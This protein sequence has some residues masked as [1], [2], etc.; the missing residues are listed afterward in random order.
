MKIELQEIVKTYGTVRANDRVDLTVESGS[1][2]GL[3]GENGAGKSTLMKILSGYVA[4][5][6]GRVLC[7]GREVKLGSPAAA[8]RLGIGML[9]QDPLDFPAL[10][11]LDNFLLGRRTGRF[12]RGEAKR[13][14]AAS[15]ARFGFT[16]AADA[17]VDDL[18]IGE[19]QQL[20][21]LRL[22]SL[23]VKALILDEPTT[24]ISESQR[25]LLFSVLK[26]LAGEGMSVI[27]VSHKLEEIEAL[28]DR[29]T[30][31][32]HGGVAGSVAMPCSAEKLVSLMFGGEIVTEQAA[33]VMNVMLGRHCRT[34]AHGPAAGKTPAI[35]LRGL[36]VG[37]A[38]VTVCDLSLAILPGEIVGLAGLEGSGQR[39]MLWAAAGLRRPQSG[40]VWLDG[41]DVT[42]ASYL[43]RRREKLA[44]VPVDRMGLG[45]VAGL[46]LTEHEAL[47]AERGFLVDWRAAAAA[48][49]THI[50]EFGIKGR[51]ASLVEE[52]SGGNQQRALLSL[53]PPELSVLLMEHPTRGLDLESADAVWEMLEARAARGTAILFASADIE[54]LL[55]RS[56]RILV[57]CAGETRLLEGEEKNAAALASLIGGRGYS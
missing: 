31:L 36:T 4:A 10:T 7:D 21:I 49:D 43:V 34:E 46:T 30:I 40:S 51:A 5:D 13:E 35:E 6:S 22:L 52:L 3:L 27:F 19:R 57:F 9:Y 1:I 20:E 48:A 53:L 11:V 26:R 45:L 23:G 39:P 28:C 15:A 37:D 32:T 17:A 41:R 29:A 8:T 2:H 54:E 18:S 55:D 42:E 16:L 56:D 47:S 38:H 50:R 14:L 12:S 33:K 24:A 44:Y 25:A